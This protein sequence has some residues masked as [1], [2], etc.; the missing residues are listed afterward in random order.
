MT[1]VAELLA[2]GREKGINGG[3]VRIVSFDER[4]AT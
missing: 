4:C 1:A 3:L 2:L